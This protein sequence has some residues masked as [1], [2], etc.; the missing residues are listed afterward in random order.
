M[1][2]MVTL[3]FHSDALGTVLEQ[4]SCLQTRQLHVRKTRSA[5]PGKFG[6]VPAFQLSPPP[7]YC[8]LWMSFTFSFG[9]RSHVITGWVI[10]HSPE[11]LLEP[12]ALVMPASSAQPLPSPGRIQSGRVPLPST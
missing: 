7:K 1:G 12:R 11:P 3:G 2:F 5:W 10:T 8:W 6:C 4:S 9:G